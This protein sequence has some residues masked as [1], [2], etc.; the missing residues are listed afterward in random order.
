M[1]PSITP[2]K[3]NKNT[4][5]ALIV[6]LS[7]LVLL[8]VVT[9]ALLTLSTKEQQA[10]T[11]Y[12]GAIK[13]EQHVRRVL[14]IVRAQV[15]EAT[16]EGDFSSPVSWTSQP[17][18]VRTFDTSGPSKI[19][20]LYSWSGLQSPASGFTGDTIPTDWAARPG[21]FTDL[22]EPVGGRFPILDPGVETLA[23]GVQIDSGSAP[24]TAPGSPMPMPVQWLY[25]LED[26]TLASATGSGNTPNI[27]GATATNQPIARVAFW[28][29]DESTKVNLNTASGGLHWSMPRVEGGGEREL[30]R[31]QPIR[32]EAQRYPGH[33]A[34][35]SIGEAFTYDDLSLSDANG[36]AKVSNAM[37]DTAQRLARLSP[38]IQYGGSLEAYASVSDPNELTTNGLD[39]L[40]LGSDSL[41]GTR[42]IQ[43]PDT[44]RF[45]ASTDE[46]LYA[47]DRTTQFADFGAPNL[48]DA[49]G[50]LAALSFVT[51]TASS[52]PETTLFETPRVSLWPIRQS[53]DLNLPPNFNS[54]RADAYDKMM[55]FAASLPDGTGRDP[56]YFVREDPMA[57]DELSGGRNLEVFNYLQSL[58]SKAV[59]GFTSS[60]AS[61]VGP[62]NRDSLLVQT[63]DMVRSTVNIAEVGMF[64]FSSIEQPPSFGYDYYFNNSPSDPTDTKRHVQ[65]T[66]HN[67]FQGFGSVPRISKVGVGFYCEKVRLLQES[68]TNPGEAG[69]PIDSDNPDA[70]FVEYTV[71][72]AILVEIFNPIATWGARPR[73]DISV[74]VTNVSG[75]G[76]HLITDP[77]GAQVEPDAV[78][79][80]GDWAPL[81]NG[82]TAKLRHP[83][84][85][86]RLA[87]LGFQDTIFIP[88]GGF[89]L[90]ENGTSP[91]AGNEATGAELWGPE[92]TLTFPMPTQNNP[93]GG[94]PIP[95]AQDITEVLDKMANSGKTK[96]EDSDGNML[97][98][99]FFS[100]WSRKVKGSHEIWVGAGSISLRLRDADV[101]PYQSALV[102]FDILATESGVPIATPALTVPY[103]GYMVA[104][105]DQSGPPRDELITIDGISS[106]KYFVSDR[107][108]SSV[109]DQVVRRLGQ[110]SSFLV[111]WGDIVLNKELAGDWRVAALD[112]NLNSA[113]DWQ[114]P[115]HAVFAQDVGN[116]AS[117][118][119]GQRRHSLINGL[120][121]IISD[122]NGRAG[123]VVA[124]NDIKTQPELVN[125]PTSAVQQLSKAIPSDVNGIAGDWSFTVPGG[126]Y[127]GIV[128]T[129]PEGGIGQLLSGAGYNPNLSRDTYFNSFFQG[130][131]F[132]GVDALPP[133]EQMTLVWSPNKQLYS[134]MQLLGSLPRRPTNGIDWETLVFSNNP[135]NLAHPGRDSDHLFADLF[136]IPIVD[137]FPASEVYSTSGKINM[138]ATIEPFGD[139]IRRE[140]ALR[141]ALTGIGI[142]VVDGD[143]KITGTKRAPNDQIP[144]FTLANAVFWTTGNDGR[145]IPEFLD[146]EWIQPLNIDDTLDGIRAYL[147]TN[148]V[149]R[150]AT[151]ITQISLVPDSTTLSGYAS[152]WQQDRYKHTADNLREEPYAQAYARLTTRSNTFKVHYRVQVLQKSAATPDNQWVEPVAA[153]DG[154]PVDAIVAEYRGHSVI[155]R[156]LD[157]NASY[158]DYTTA[159]NPPLLSTFYRWRTLLSTRFS[160]N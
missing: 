139:Y 116:L 150:S 46:F 122:W 21:V 142:P 65:A 110:I 25:I 9:V 158:P 159:S 93:A 88:A 135:I 70:A 7:G 154:S 53:A 119:D 128:P 92:I 24:P 63:F 34:G 15:T 50:D 61:D 127:G 156:Y 38:R 129:A 126:A 26:G 114:Y 137:P 49:V 76:L 138:N 66:Q 54:N 107:N 19:Y 73:Y 151:E 42:Q 62:P 33:P 102:T 56:Y 43:A 87:H 60:I 22:N 131:K 94:D 11:G 147:D 39:P 112:D 13:A 31:F 84:T 35:V 47:P 98:E 153:N 160:G 59:P 104:D 29:D 157:P 36:N 67:G 125:N 74:E 145:F 48:A 120:S 6:V 97:S 2:P 136:W 44:D 77:T 111:N 51:T 103:F 95:F 113:S 52:A 117:W 155:E 72:P 85:N 124:D 132:G 140:T 17:G 134:P 16:T 141:A 105:T 148:E 12:S 121:S 130:N 37:G 143:D 82:R 101:N 86:N 108:G 5:F 123:R 32:F 152:F 40:V 133:G 1:K 79:S 58:T 90:N 100:E 146:T 45:Y 78:I 80:G 27:A 71:R 4:G 64:E 68:E 144:K 83:G 8:L 109:D 115:M 99:A 23:N 41:S 91:Y 28:T 18:M 55:A 96:I 57:D 75:L 10:A 30:G 20:K 81:M 14:D 3:R 149:F 106:A 69:E 118:M 89:L